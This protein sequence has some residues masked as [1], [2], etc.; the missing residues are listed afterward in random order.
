MFSISTASIIAVSS[1][2]VILALAA[3]FIY[4]LVNLRRVVPT[5]M[6]HIVQ[7]SKKSTPYGRGK[8]AGNTYYAWPEWVPV[9][10]VTVSQFPESIFKVNLSNYDAYDENRLPFVVDVVAFF[11]VDNAETAAQRV[12]SFEELLSQL[13]EIL[14]GSV[15]RILGTNTLEHI[16]GERSVFGEQFTEEVRSQI[17]E[18]GV[19]PVKSIEF[20]DIHDAEGSRVIE[21]I[22]AKE[23]SRID[24]ES[25][26]Q[27]AE[28]EKEAQ[29][30]EIDAQRTVDVQR[31]DAL[32]QVGQRTA[33]KD[34]AV[35]ISTEQAR[36]EV[37]AQAKTTAERTMEVKKVEEIKTAEIQ[38]D[39]A[40]IKAEQDKSVQIIKA[41]ADKTT[42]ITR[43]EAEQQSIKITSDGNLYATKQSAEGI[44]AEGEAKASAEKAMLMAP[45]ETQITLAKEIGENQGY[46]NYL[47]TIKQVEVSGDVGKE[48]AKAIG[49]A[50]LKVIANSGDIQG[51]VASLGDLFSAKGGTNLTGMLSALAQSPEGAALLNKFTGSGNNPATSK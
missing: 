16:L 31:Q 47:I 35:G 15:R 13:N 26:I 41:E 48:L 27:V 21:N 24:K 6:V 14:R 12:A 42:Q 17:E 36:Q 34:K 22:M 29:L 40:A 49:N 18:W 5:N 51:G 38:K 45:V 9:I 23:Q 11:R 43:A 3:T 50:D 7:S 44:T 37:L 39:V 20:M 30:R 10:G 8:N 46:Q 1:I 28:N 33:D 4:I 2:V 25:R 19:L 32:Q